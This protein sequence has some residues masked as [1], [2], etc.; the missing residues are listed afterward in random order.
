MKLHNKTIY[1]YKAMI[2][3]NEY[4]FDKGDIIDFEYSE[5][6]VVELKCLKKPSVHLDWLQIIFLQMFFGSTTITNIYADY[7]FVINS[8]EYEIIEIN[9]NDWNL[10]EQININTCYAD[11]GVTD[12]EY[13]LPSLKKVRKKHK[14]FHLFVSNALP[15]G[16]GCFV[17]CFFTDPPTPFIIL[18][19]VWLLMF[20]L[21]GIKEIKRFKQIMKP[22][23]L[24]EKLCEYAEN[25]R[26]HIFES[27]RDL[28]KTGKFAIK[29]INKM[30]KFDEDKK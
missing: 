14:N 23:F 1:N 19:I 9:N 21:P 4:S 26:K 17:L 15:L 20:E 10:K 25:K 22:D 7:S 8:N 16:I 30:F 18:F 24:N 28:S 27:D 5:N 6:T 29:I 3:G 11:V 13:K 12:E 2:N